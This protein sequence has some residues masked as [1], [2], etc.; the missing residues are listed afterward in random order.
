[1]KRKLFVMLLAVT[2]VMPVAF[3]GCGKNNVDESHWKDLQNIVEG[4]ENLKEAGGGEND[5][6]NS[7]IYDVERFNTEP[8]E[9]EEESIQAQRGVIKDGMFVN[10]TFKIAFPLTDDM[11][12]V[13]DELIAEAQGYTMHGVGEDG[14]YSAEQME[15]DTN[16]VV[17][18]TLI[19][20]PDM[21]SNIVVAFDNM[22]V[23][24]NGN[25][26][27]AEQYANVGA[28]TIGDHIQMVQIG[29]LDYVC[30]DKMVDGYSATW[31]L[32]QEANY[33]IMI[34]ITFADDYSSDDFIASFVTVE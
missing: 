11:T 7:E 15:L 5:Y 32:R 13:N 4:L 27:T 16:G 2:L 19:F 18:D 20:M 10:E 21:H 3:L 17:Y 31:L 22:D 23:T 8:E 29:G 34:N 1:M 9:P 14:V 33:M 24:R 30:A 26:L 12:V 25:R 28:E 6:F